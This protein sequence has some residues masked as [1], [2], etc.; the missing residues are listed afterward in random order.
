M[1]TKAKIRASIK[2]D[3]S[4]TKDIRIKLNLKT[5]ADIIH[6]LEKCSNKQ[7]EIKRLIREEIK[8]KDIA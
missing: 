1:S 2:Y 7:G 3:K 8:R 6:F 4:N 5:D